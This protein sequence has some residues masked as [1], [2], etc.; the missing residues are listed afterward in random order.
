MIFL[1]LFN[2]GGAGKKEG[3]L[4]S[5]A[6]SQS[7]EQTSV[8]GNGN[9][10]AAKPP[11]NLP[12]VVKATVGAH[13]P[14]VKD[15]NKVPPSKNVEAAEVKDRLVG[16][17]S[18]GSQLPK[19]NV[20]SESETALTFQSSSLVD[21]PKNDSGIAVATAASASLVILFFH[22]IGFYQ[23]LYYFLLHIIFLYTGK[24]FSL[25]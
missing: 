15:C 24:L 23:I 14:D 1:L 11:P 3:S 18:S 2:A 9:S 16:N 6:F 12:D 22:V 7:H 19:E 10:T 4:C 8:T 20:V 13:D 21:L 17:A 25:C 5:A